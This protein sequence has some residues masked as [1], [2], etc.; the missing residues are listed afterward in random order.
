M[1][2]RL[3]FETLYEEKVALVMQSISILSEINESDTII[4]KGFF[5]DVNKV[6]IKDYDLK[7]KLLNKNTKFVV[8]QIKKDDK[9]FRKLE[10][11][12]R[13][14]ERRLIARTKCGQ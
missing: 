6:I 1:A 9:T 13:N 2:K 3:N 8:K 11:K 12:V 14:A 4:P 7:I 10:R 5:S